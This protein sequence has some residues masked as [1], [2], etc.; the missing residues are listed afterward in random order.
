MI[1]KKRCLHKSRAI[2]ATGTNNCLLKG[3]KL[4]SLINNV[5]KLVLK[6]ELVITAG[7]V[8]NDEAVMCVACFVSADEF[9]N[10]IPIPLIDLVMTWQNYVSFPPEYSNPSNE[11][12]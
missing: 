9:Y 8:G 1:N 7:K 2:F 12:F 5:D 4:F 10:N 3:R 11:I 6:G